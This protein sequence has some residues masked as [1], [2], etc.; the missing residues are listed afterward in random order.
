MSIEPGQNTPNKDEGRG[1]TMILAVLAAAVFILAL[2]A[3]CWGEASVG[4]RQV[5]HALGAELGLSGEVAPQTRTVIFDLRLPRVVLAVV[6]GF[7]LALAGA[8]VQGVLMNPL[9]SPYVLGVSSGAA[10]GAAGAIALGVS[11]AGAGRFFVVGNAFCMAMLAMLLAYGIAR[12]R[13]ATP[14]T[15]I[16]AGIAISY[17]FAGMVSLLQYFSADE[18]LR[19]I[20]FWMM[21]SLWNSRWETIYFIAPVA[22]IGFVVLMLLAWDMNSLG[23]GEEVARSLGVNVGRVR[24]FALV[25]GAMLTGCVVAFTGAIGFIGLM[26]P[27]IARLLVGGDHRY[28]IPASGL[29]GSCLLVLADTL[30]RNLL[31]PMELPVGIMTSMV[32]GPFFIYLLLKRRRD[33]WA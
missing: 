12:L 23:S 3:V 8:A 24:L 4:F 20:V 32:G 33:W 30:A 19:D 9:V 28:L 6:A 29:V 25:A 1:R 21:G 22:A 15:I 31:W 5:V 14:E 16:L 11:L 26:S 27:H 17:M 18:K 10:F 7:G 13:R 2:T